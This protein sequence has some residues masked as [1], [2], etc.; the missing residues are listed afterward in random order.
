MGCAVPPCLICDLCAA[1]LMSSR[2]LALSTD[3]ASFFQENFLG[4]WLA[5]TVLLLNIEIPKPL[6]FS[7]V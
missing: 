3:G 4:C 5:L 6:L 7:R 2:M 1:C